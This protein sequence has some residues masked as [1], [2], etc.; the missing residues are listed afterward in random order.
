[1]KMCTVM[2]DLLLSRFEG[3]KTFWLDSDFNRRSEEDC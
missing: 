2:N 3:E 1:M